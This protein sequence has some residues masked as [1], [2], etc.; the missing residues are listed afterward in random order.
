MTRDSIIIGAG[1]N[2]LIAAA[3]LAR[4]G[5]KAV[6]LERRDIVGGAAVTEEF[7]PGFRVS[8]ASYSLSL[9][10]PDIHEE[11]ALASRGLVI[12]PKD[13]QMFIPL[14]EGQ[15]LFI[16][17]DSDRTREE[18]TRIHPPDADAYLRWNAFW[19]E[20][21]ALLRPMVDSPDP[22]NLDEVEKYLVSKG[23]EDVWRLAVAGSA[24]ATVEEFFA[25]DELRGAFAS[26]GIIGTAAGPREP[27]TAWVMTYHFIGGEVNGADGTWGYVM[28]GMGSLTQKLAEAAREHGCEIRT[29]ADVEQIIVEDGAIRGVL[30]RNG[31]VIEASRVLSGADPV[32]TFSLLE[33]PDEETTERLEAWRLDGCVVKVNLALSALPEFKSLPGAVIGPQHRGT[34]EISPS[35][36]Y[37]QNAYEDSQARSFSKAPFIEAFVQSAVDPS[38]A[39]EGSHVMSAF[40]QYA[41]KV[42]RDRWEELKPGALQAVIETLN[43]HAPNLR[44]SVVSAQV[45]GPHDLE[46]RFGLTGGDIFHGAIVPEQ[47]FG[48]RFGYRTPVEGL[49]LCGSGAA[50][51]GGVMGA[52]G[53]NAALTVLEDMGRG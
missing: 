32:R 4:R 8:T 9:L 51:G 14:P 1:H 47:C 15:H 26:Q 7:H 33:S 24:A 30:L 39:P 52:A 38:V 50:P 17:R 12:Q 21:V 6:V 41:P 29:G 28:G 36:S 10:R 35:I 34:I 27:G 20:A 53:R 43:S 2:G 25:S 16:W 19:D 18:I 22:P 5:V 40:T 49:Y 42:D 11:L 45:L 13:P 31:E 37:L 3:Y 44:D 48:E 23:R 46:E